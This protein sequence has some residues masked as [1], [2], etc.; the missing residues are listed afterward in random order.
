LDL[1]QCGHTLKFSTTAKTTR[2]QLIKS[3]LLL[4][5]L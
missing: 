4:L 1:N 2:M 3:L 5:D